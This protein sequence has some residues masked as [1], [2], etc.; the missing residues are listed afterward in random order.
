MKKLILKNDIEK[1]LWIDIYKRAVT[2]VQ[3]PED[4]ADNSIKKFRK[5]NT[6]TIKTE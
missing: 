1:M 5:R 4:F 6:Q 2:K 3:Y